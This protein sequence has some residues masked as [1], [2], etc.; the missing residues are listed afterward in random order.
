[1]VTNQE[2][3][4]AFANA[5]GRPSFFRIPEAVLNIMFN[6]ER[7]KIITQGQ[8]VLPKRVLEYGFHYEYPNIVDACKE[9][10]RFMY[11]SKEPLPGIK[12]FSYAQ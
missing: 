1:M 8:K 9:C 12:K 5:M 3:S 2:F 10:A 4:S 7:A 11:S 6:E